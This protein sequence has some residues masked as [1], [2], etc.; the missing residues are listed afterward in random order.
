MVHLIFGNS[1]VVPVSKLNCLRKAAG[2]IL[3]AS[4]TPPNM[5]HSLNSLK[6]GYIGDYVG[7][8]FRGY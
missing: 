3:R 8:Y 6:G 5:S 1:L 7:D 2:S 4:K